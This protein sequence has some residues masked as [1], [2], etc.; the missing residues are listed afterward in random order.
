MA[1]I[2]C[3]ECSAQVSDQAV[4]C[5]KCGYPIKKAAPKQG[6]AIFK[7]SKE[8]IG[9]ACSYAIMDSRGN[10]L[11]KLKPGESYEVKINADTKFSVKYKGGLGST[12]EVTAN[13]NEV[14]RFAVGLSQ[15]GMGLTISRVDVIDSD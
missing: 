14:N 12:K 1:M 3:P 7:A 10:I 11:A 8:F 13:A 15:S 2:T 6:K 9:L 4:S 5:I